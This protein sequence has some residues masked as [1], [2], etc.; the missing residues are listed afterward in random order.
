MERE[1][2][3]KFLVVGGAKV[4]KTCFVTKY[5]KG[6]ISRSYYPT[7]GCDVHTSD[8]G[9][10]KNRMVRLQFLDISHAEI[11]S[12]H[13]SLYAS[14][15]SGVFFLFDSNDPESLRHLDEWYG[16]LLRFLP[17]STPMMLIAHKSD[18]IKPEAMAVSQSKLNHY[19]M[20]LIL[21]I[22]LP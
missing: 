7:I 13:H 21:P 10:L 15:A 8:Y 12:N 11:T 18:L 3:L 4:G 5:R 1:L 2:R 9:I 20:V 22:Y 14:Q 16:G 19:T 17:S 6:N